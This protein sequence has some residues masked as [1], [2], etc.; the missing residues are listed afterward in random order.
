MNLERKAYRPI[1]AAEVIGTSRSTIYLW[2]QRG[3]I[4][5]VR[6]GSQQRIPAAELDRLVEEGVPTQP[7]R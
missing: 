6:F 2:M 7:T 4:K 1:E 3:L 5:T